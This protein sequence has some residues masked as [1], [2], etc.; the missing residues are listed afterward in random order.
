MSYKSSSAENSQNDSDVNFICDYV[1]EVEDDANMS[2]TNACINEDEWFL[3]SYQHK[4]IANTDWIEK[5]N[6][7]RRMEQDRL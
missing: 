1:I 7:E 2:S 6:E 5:Y 4:P 3:K